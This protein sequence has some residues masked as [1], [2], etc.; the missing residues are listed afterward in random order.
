MT[1][2]LSLS[3]FAELADAYGGVIARW[4]EPYRDVASALARDPAAGA[5]LAR[6][7]LLD[8]ELDEW[9]VPAPSTGLRDAVSPRTADHT[10]VRRARL[11]WSGIG[12]AA[13]LAGATAG[14]TA[15]AMLSPTDVSD[16]MT[17][18]GDIGP[19]ES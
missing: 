2:P 1:E 13:A 18:F 3:R 12:I 10:I 4:P 7:S 14:A 9:R 8:E 17:S 11:W 5:I 15:V 6:A 16:G 19:Q